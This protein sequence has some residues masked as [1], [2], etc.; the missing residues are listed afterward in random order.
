MNNIRAATITEA[1]RSSG[2]WVFIDL[3]FASQ[4]KSCGLLIG[5]GEAQ[6]LSFS[7]LQNEVLHL[8]SKQGAPLNIVLEAPLSV[9]FGPSGNPTGRSI[10]KRDGQ[11]RYWYLGLGCS[12]LVAATYLLRSMHELPLSREVRLFEGLVS[13]KQKG[14][15]SS[16][17]QD[18]SDLREVAWL[19]N[20]SKGRIVPPDE[21]AANRGD[22]VISA[23]RVAGMDFGV[24]PVIAIG[25]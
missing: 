9:A 7:D 4:T 2:E 10:E 16:H 5:E 19:Q 6:T 13:F 14:T 18:V 20:K 21:L 24:P 8:C 11:V 22:R 12:V 25:A 1:N 23:F 17:I 3:G 15:P